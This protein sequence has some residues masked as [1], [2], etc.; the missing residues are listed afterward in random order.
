MTESTPKKIRPDDLQ[1]FCIAAMVKNGLS[2]EDAELSARVFVTTDTWGTFTHG[3]RQIRGLM[4][5]ARRGRL[6]ATARERIVNEGPSWAIIDA[7]DGMPPSICC[8]AVELAVEK[9]RQSGMCY[10]GIRRSSH[11][12]AAGFYSNMIAERGMIGLSVCNVEPIVV[13]PGSKSRIVGTNPIAYAVPTGTDRTVMFDIATSTVAATKIFAA[14]NE[15]RSI[16]DTWLVDEDGVPTTDPTG[17]PEA[18]ALLPMTGHKGYGLAVLVEIL[19]ATLSGAAMMHSVE[20]WV[21]DTDE[22]SNQGHAFMVINVGAMMPLEEFYDRMATMRAE[23]K[24]GT[25]VEGGTIFLPGEI[26]WNNREVAMAEG[27]ALP[28]DVLISLRGLAEDSELDPADF[29][30]DLG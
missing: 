24:S 29:G 8:R 19:S 5:N 23:I 27:M 4:K 13:A 20:S 7:C 26:D 28:E 15:G 6:V 16:P 11:Y 22:P 2:Q 18:G 21:K 30:L 25:P 3:T 14:K 1:S 9:A 17:F 10:I 12:G